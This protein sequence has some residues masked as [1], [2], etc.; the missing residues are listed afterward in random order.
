M[1][2]L[3]S[4]R[5]SQKNNAAKVNACLVETAEQLVAF[6]L[7]SLRS[8]WGQSA[9]RS[10]TFIGF[11]PHTQRW[12]ATWYRSCA[13]TNF[14]SSFILF[15][16]LFNASR[17]CQCWQT[18]WVLYLFGEY[19]ERGAIKLRYDRCLWRIV[20]APRKGKNERFNLWHSVWICRT[21]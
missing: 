8:S 20:D 6:G 3:Q 21:C 12:R 19:L 18:G 10:S 14:L 13:E 17:M 9:L 5:S 7:G 1:E 15:L 2:A 4:G 11:Y 16:Y